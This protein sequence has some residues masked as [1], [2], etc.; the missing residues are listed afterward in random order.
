V[1]GY[2]YPAGRTDAQGRLVLTRDSIQSFAD[3]LRGA[4]D[5]VAVPT[6]TIAIPPTAPE[7]ES[8]GASDADT[9]AGAS[10]S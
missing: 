9:D 6:D 1:E 4:P 7:P 10:G 5:E 3:T 8:A 2:P